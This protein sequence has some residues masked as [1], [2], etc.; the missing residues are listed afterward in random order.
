MTSNIG[1]LE[2][3]RIGVRL[4]IAA[5][6][7]AMLFLFAYGDIFGFLNTGRIEEVI[8]TGIIAKHLIT[9]ARKACAGELN[10]S[11]YSSKVR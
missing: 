3:G 7:I 10:A 8:A 5:L 9:F 11:H 2:D 4:K 1:I 6:W